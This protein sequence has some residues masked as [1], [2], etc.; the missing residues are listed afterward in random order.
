MKYAPLGSYLCNGRQVAH[1]FCKE[2][3]MEFWNSEKTIVS[4]NL[5]LATYLMYQFSSKLIINYYFVQI[6]KVSMVDLRTS[7]FQSK[8]GRFQN[9]I[10]LAI[11]EKAANFYATVAI[12]NI[13]HCGFLHH[14]GKR[15]FFLSF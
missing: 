10:I 12:F 8:H 5:S 9:K 13:F 11:L 1:H 2:N 14:D 6:S 7:N 4:S 15:L 3:Y